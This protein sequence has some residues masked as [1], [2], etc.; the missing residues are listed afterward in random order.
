MKDELLIDEE[1]AKTVRYIFKLCCDG[2]GPTQIANRLRWEQV[3]TPTAYKAQQRG[4]LLPE[5]P[6]NWTQ[7]TVSGIL[8]KVEYLG[9]TENFKT[10][11]KNYR[12]KKRVK[13]AKEERKLFR[14]THPAIVDEHTFQVVQEIRSH[15]HRPIQHSK[16]LFS[17]SG[18]LQLRQLP[19][20]H[21]YL[22]RPL[23]PGGDTGEDCTGPHE[24]CSG[25]CP[26]V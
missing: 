11:S 24:A 26:A 13:T 18:F 7:K 16:Q 8:D 25:I 9:H 17:K 23:Y 3:L 20:Q 1:A 2:L 12:S 14:D 4:E 10:A 22:H 5:R 15:R 19:Q 21:R 6:F